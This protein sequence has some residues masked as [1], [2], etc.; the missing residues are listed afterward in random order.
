MPL[1]APYWC[2]STERLCIITIKWL[3][4]HFKCSCENWSPYIWYIMH[5]KHP[6]MDRHYPFR[7]VLRRNPILLF[8]V[9]AWCHAIAM[10]KITKVADCFINHPSMAL[11][12]EKCITRAKHSKNKKL[13]KDVVCLKKKKSL[14]V[15]GWT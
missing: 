7:H 2:F 14:S 1:F 13:I 4:L 6:E 12:N 3:P 5:V 9:Q 11:P 15:F 10:A 8:Y